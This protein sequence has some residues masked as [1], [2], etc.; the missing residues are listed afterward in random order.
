MD[1]NIKVREGNKEVLIYLPQ[2]YPDELS[3][4]KEAAK[5]LQREV[6]YRESHPNSNLDR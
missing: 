6:V 5:M 1:Q 3:A 4:L 2:F